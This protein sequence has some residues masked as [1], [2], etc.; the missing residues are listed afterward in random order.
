MTAT[1]EPKQ[2]KTC[3]NCSCPM[4]PPVCHACGWEDDTDD[5]DLYT[6]G[7]DDE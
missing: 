1:D 2:A 5:T 6:G 7:N 3:P 4:F